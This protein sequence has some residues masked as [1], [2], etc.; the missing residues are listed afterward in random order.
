LPYIETQGRRIHH[1]PQI[2]KVVPYDYLSLMTGKDLQ[3]NDLINPI[4]E[5]DTK[6][7]EVV[8]R[9][10]TSS[11]GAMKIVHGVNNDFIRNSIHKHHHGNNGVD[12]TFS[13]FVDASI[14]L[15][16]DLDL[17]PFEVVVRSFEFGVNVPL[18]IEIQSYKFLRHCKT[19]NGKQINGKVFKNTNALYLAAELDNFTFKLYQ[20]GGQLI[21]EVQGIDPNLFRAE[22]H[23]D[24]MA[25]CKSIGITS[26]APFV[27]LLDPS[28]SFQLIKLL[29]QEFDKVVFYDWTTDQRQMTKPERRIFKN[30]KD[31]V[32]IEDLAQNNPR[33]Y[34]H[35]IA[36]FKRISAKYSNAHIKETVW[37]LIEKKWFEIWQIDKKTCTKL[38]AFLSRYKNSNLYDFTSSILVVN[39]YNLIA[40]DAIKYLEQLSV[41]RTCRITSVDISDQRAGS[42]FVSAKKIGYYDA[43]NV[44]N[45]DS[46][47]RNNLRRS[48]ERIAK[49]PSLFPL[50]AI[51][52]ITSDQ[53]R[54]LEYWQGTQYDILKRVGVN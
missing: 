17:N 13:D 31:P 53:K 6:T 3:G 30:W 28:K 18:P 45:T 11:Y 15:F 2:F 27:V 34:K 44:R 43:H 36:M 40:P 20:K 12:F 52:T 50:D 7:G 9:V 49:E 25:Y 38:H 4:A 21:R 23:V 32:Y 51:L 48:I 24:R 5:Y 29:R 54:I 8:S 37:N 46:N 14:S 47:P 19:F 16:E 26:N 1:Q 39:Q 22:L 42:K 10:Q 35:E 33:K 41:N